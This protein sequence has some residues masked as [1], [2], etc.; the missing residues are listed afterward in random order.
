[1]M[2][3]HVYALRC[4]ASFF[5]RGDNL[6]KEEQLVSLNSLF[7]QPRSTTGFFQ[8]DIDNCRTWGV[9]LKVRRSVEE[10]CHLTDI[11]WLMWKIRC[12]KWVQ[13]IP[14]W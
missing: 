8:R 13:V 14:K 2:F 4:V 3:V 6:P 5:L 1:M 9:Q 12:H 11:V 10:W 7:V